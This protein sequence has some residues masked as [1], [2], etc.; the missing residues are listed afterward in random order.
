MRT[1]TENMHMQMENFL[2]TLAPSIDHRAETRQTLLT[3]QA[4]RQQQHFAKQRLL[5]RVASSQALYVG[6]RHDEKMHRGQRP[7]IVED[8]DFIILVDFAGRNIHRYD[9]A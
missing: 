8:D 7:E 5:I 1:A 2:A 3:G 4:R 6:S 9:L